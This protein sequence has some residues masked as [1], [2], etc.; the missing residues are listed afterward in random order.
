MIQKMALAAVVVLTVSVLSAADSPTPASTS[1]IEDE[2][3]SLESRYL[4]Q[5]IA[6]NLDE[7][8]ELWHARFLGW[9]SHSP[10]PVDRESGRLS[11]EE[12]LSGNRFVSVEI[13]PRGIR[14]VDGVAIAHYIATASREEETGGTSSSMMRLTHTWMQT[15]TGWKILGGMSSVHE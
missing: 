11:L 4:N 12:F 6:G 10:N 9:P 13:Q 5:V 2:I 3:W 15:P 14:V 8:Q 1:E 7:V